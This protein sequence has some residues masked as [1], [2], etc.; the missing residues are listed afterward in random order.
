MRFTT[1]RLC[2][3]EALMAIPADT[4]DLDMIKAADVLRDM[5]GNIKDADDMM[6][7]FDWEG[8]ETTIYPQG[9]IM[10]FPLKDRSLCIKYAAD[11]LGKLI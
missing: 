6:I 9:K 10:F 1:M 4:L 2:G 8:M 7:V 5:G 11:I 3:G